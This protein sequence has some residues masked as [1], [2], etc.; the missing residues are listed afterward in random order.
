MLKYKMLDSPTGE[1]KIR[2]QC[3]VKP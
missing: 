2:S 1:L 3:E